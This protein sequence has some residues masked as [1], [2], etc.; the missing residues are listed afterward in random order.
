MGLAVP[1]LC[2]ADGSLIPTGAVMARAG[3]RGTSCATG[4]ARWS[5][6]SGFGV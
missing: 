4:A 1:V 5:A 6:S 2:G 3:H